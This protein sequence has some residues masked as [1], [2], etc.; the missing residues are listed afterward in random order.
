VTQQPSSPDYPARPGGGYPPPGGG[1]PPP[2]P[3]GAY[4]PPAPGG[5]YPPMAPMPPAKPKKARRGIITL[6]VTLVVV[7]V[8]AIIGVLANRDSPKQTAVGDCMSGQTAE[9]LKKVACTDS[10][11]EWKVVG[12]V[13]NKTESEAKPETACTQWPETDSAY[14]EGKPGE[15]GFVLC[16]APIKK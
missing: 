9:T 7:A 4:P 12:R 3:G 13:G 11:A 15:S 8:V 10:T 5:A 16:L 14:W 2:A 6:V 1:Y